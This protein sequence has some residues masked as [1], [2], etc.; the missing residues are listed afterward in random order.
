MLKRAGFYV[1]QMM[2]FLSSEPVGGDDGK[3]VIYADSTN[4]FELSS[5]ALGSGAYISTPVSVANGGTAST[6]A[7]DARTALGLAIG[8]NVQAY[9][10][11]LAALAGLTSA[12]DKLPYF[13][14]S[15]T[16]A[17]ADL[18]ST[19][20]T[21]IDDASTSAMRTTLG[22][23][24]GTDVQAY[25]GDLAAIAA[26]TH[27]EGAPIYSNG[28]AWTT[29]SR[30]AFEMMMHLTPT[31]WTNMPAAATELFGATANRR[32][33][34]ATG[35]RQFRIN[36]RHGVVGAAG[37]KLY[38]QYSTDNVTFADAESGGHSS[39]DYALDA[40]ASTPYTT[41]WVN[42]ATG[43]KAD[44]YWRIVGQTGDG[45]ADPNITSI[46]VQFR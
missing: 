18:S 10:A 15:G 39:G 44:V 17:L 13:T 21:L 26:L 34:D 11:E 2:D 5:S 36:A 25:D 46:G 23:A 8:A 29:S 32:K 33:L 20:R 30:T 42:L 12:A 28:S 37:S 3:A 4:S 27:T 24:I 1:R 45:A 31:V 22:L 16:A 43:A 9:D 19:A 6:T 35:Y 38:L 41:T 14:G 7:S 40:A